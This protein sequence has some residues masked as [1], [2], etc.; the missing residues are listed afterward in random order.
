M[1]FLRTNDKGIPEDISVSLR[2][3]DAWKYGRLK[4]LGLQGELAVIA[5]D[6]VGGLL[7]AATN[8]GYIY[9]FGSPA[10]THCIR[11]QGTAA[12]AGVKHLG[13]SMSATRLIACDTRNK[14][15]IW[16]LSSSGLPVLEG[17]LHVGDVV[18]CMA[19]SVYH[20]H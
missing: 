15:H 18:N 3:R 14:L 6:V 13:W 16:S 20:S 10:A 11:L 4:N 1:D 9:I 7:A 12:D 2:D 17:S 5:S 8:S 19:T